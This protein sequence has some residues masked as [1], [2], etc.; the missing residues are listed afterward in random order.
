[1]E[2]N[3]KKATTRDEMKNLLLTYINELLKIAIERKSED[4]EEE[5][6]KEPFAWM[7]GKINPEYRRTG[8]MA[9]TAGTRQLY[10][11]G[12]EKEATERANQMF[13]KIQQDENIDNQ[14]QDC[15]KLVEMIRDL[16][17]YEVIEK[18]GIFG[19]R[20]EGEGG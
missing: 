16:E 4:P 10:M 13:E 20:Q 19:K 3:M 1:M 8:Y 15:Y 12:W 9:E 17:R 18:V 11:C 5:A 7:L 14:M 6:D 2:E